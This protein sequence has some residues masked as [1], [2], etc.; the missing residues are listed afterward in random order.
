M[1]FNALV[2]VSARKA[3]VAPIT[4]VTFIAVHNVLLVNDWWFGSFHST[5]CWN[6]L[7]LKTS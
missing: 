3:D 7:L 5:S 4:P 2:G 6:C 1:H